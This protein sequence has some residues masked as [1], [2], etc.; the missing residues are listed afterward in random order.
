M[1]VLYYLIN[2]GI[3]AVGRALDLLSTYYITPNLE[4][5]TN[6]L[7][8]RLGWKGSVLLQVP[9]VVFG[10]L[11]RPAAVF[12]FAW[13]IIIAA[14]NISGAWFVRNLPGGDAQY[15]DLLE[16]SAKKAKL[17]NIILDESPPLVFYTI[18]NILVWIAIH[19]GVGNVIDLLVQETF[20]SYVLVVTGA[21][22]F[23]GVMGFIRNVLYINKLRK[24]KPTEAGAEER[25]TSSE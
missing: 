18:P 12:F 7:I 10:A 22:M 5:E 23:H 13:S 15:A 8:S 14:S 25:P 9:L 3:T 24:K 2:A 21:F 20:I 16:Q 19:L 17:R 1:T 6:T 11:I 4:L